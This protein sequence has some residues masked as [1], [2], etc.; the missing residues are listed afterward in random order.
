M[1][2]SPAE[3]DPLGGWR[4]EERGQRGASLLVALGISLFVAIILVALAS[5]IS[6]HQ[7]SVS[8][9][10][11]V[12]ATRYATDAA[13]KGAINWVS[14]VEDVGRDPQVYPDDEPCVYRVPGQGNVPDIAVTCEPV[15]DSDSGVP[16]ET[17]R[18]PD[19]ALLLL[20][21]RYGEPPLNSPCVG[22]TSNRTDLKGREVGLLFDP[23]R[24]NASGNCVGGSSIGEFRVNG[25][26]RSNAPIRSNSG[27]PLRLTTGSSV[28]AGTSPIYGNA[29]CI[30]LPTLVNAGR[31]STVPANARSGSFPGRP[32]SSPWDPY[33]T[34]FTDPARDGSATRDEWR[35][36]TINWTTP[37]VSIN[38]G[39]LQELS[40]S[41]SLAAC[42][43]L[44]SDLVRFYPGHYRSAEALNRIFNDTVGGKTC[45]HGVFWFGPAAD[46]AAASPTYSPA[47]GSAYEPLDPDTAVQGVYLFDFRDSL[48]GRPKGVNGSGRKCGYYTNTNNPHRWCLK[49]DATEG[50]PMLIAGTPK[51]FD[52]AAL[53]NSNDGAQTSTLSL[54][55]AGTVQDNGSLTWENQSGARTIDGSSARYN[56]F[57]TSVDRSFTLRNFS[58]RVN[59]VTPGGEV[60][61]HVAH[62][63][64]NR[65]TQLDRPQIGLRTTDRGVPIDCGW[66]SFAQHSTLTTDVLSTNPALNTANTSSDKFSGPV[67]P[68]NTADLMRLRNCTSNAERVNNLTIT[69]RATGAWTNGL[70]GLLYPK[71]YPHLDGVRIDVESPTGGWFDAGVETPAVY[72]DPTAPGVQFIFGG[73]STLAAGGSGNNPPAVQICAGPAPEDPE[74]YQQVAVWGQ[75]VNYLTKDSAGTQ[76]E[77]RI[78]RTA[79]H[80][81]SLRPRANSGTGHECPGAG[82]NSNTPEFSDPERGRNPGN[83]YTSPANPTE[84]PGGVVNPAVCV[85]YFPPAPLNSNTFIT[86][87]NFGKV[88]PYTG[89]GNC[90]ADPSVDL[91]YDP[92]TETLERVE[93]K[94]AYNSSCGVPDINGQ[95]CSGLTANS[96]YTITGPGVSGGSCSNTEAFPANAEVRWYTIDVTS[97]LDTIEKL[98]GASVRFNMKCNVCVGVDKYFAGL[99]LL[100]T[101]RPT[102]ATTKVVS[103]ASGC[104]VS[105]TGYG[106]GIGD[107]A[108]VNTT[109][110]SA[111][112]SSR[113]CALISGGRVSVQGTIFAPSSA[114]EIFDGDNLHPF[115][116]RGVV[117]RHLRVRQFRYRDGYNEPIIGSTA[118]K[119]P[120]PREVTFTACARSVSSDEPCGSL[121]DDDV[122]GSTRVR[123]DLD[124]AGPTAQPSV[125]R[126]VWWRPLQT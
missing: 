74:D 57:F 88:R 94:V 13:L 45:R 55:T 106:A 9:Y 77:I 91:C 121:P 15:P 60:S 47:V 110:Y 51:G 14:N 96:G 58:P 90:T 97:C 19:Q 8:A 24:P 29:A 3:R 21:T 48:A 39:P 118:D 125:P 1:A 104:Q 78:G 40:T 32:A 20:G 82:W 35:Q 49:V 17:G 42:K 63:V 117:A 69:Y 5:Y 27:D 43:G 25:D 65:T 11:N 36:G 93:L 80:P 87:S 83:R 41:T 119:T 72:C 100:V 73:D 101:M 10:R 50:G 4:I 86:Y 113:D 28:V 115:A 84:V 75:P 105:A 18:T 61:I 126:I 62:Y 34:L 103:P 124:R 67:G 56:A 54:T 53:I 76:Q 122:L 33:E 107:Y 123:F 70:W 31:C 6:A 102:S 59:A 79:A 16:V 23:I 81:A 66:F 46:E 98:N 68:L 38:G 44:P 95:W 108:A 64:Q 71:P 112:S 114:L 85:L 116:T 12:R 120:K 30:G 89:S 7:K 99:E 26:I 37:R 22:S 111:T 109:N 2:P 52:P 92:A